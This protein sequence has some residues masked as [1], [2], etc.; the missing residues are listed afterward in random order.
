MVELEHWVSFK[1]RFIGGFSSFEIIFIEQFECIE[2]NVAIDAHFGCS[3]AIVLQFFLK[4][5]IFG[6]F[7]F[8]S[9]DLK[10]R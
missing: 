8:K 10:F 5:C 2:F 1:W 4:R 9:L 3:P 7:Y 6:Y